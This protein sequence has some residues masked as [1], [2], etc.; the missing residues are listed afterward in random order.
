MDA[1]KQS[2]R[3]V[4]GDVSVVG[5]DD[6]PLAAEVNPP[7][8]TIHVPKETMGIIA[9]ALYTGG[10]MSKDDIAGNWGKYH[11]PIILSAHTAIA[12]TNC[13][14]STSPAKR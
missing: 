3:S 1:I 5:F 12:T 4:P 8:S 2:G 10:L 6:I 14:K 11:W 9:G 7:L 13:A